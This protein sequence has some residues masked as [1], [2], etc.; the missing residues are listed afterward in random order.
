MHTPLYFCSFR[1]RSQ[2]R[3]RTLLPVALPTEI[4]CRKYSLRVY[5]YFTDSFVNQLIPVL[6]SN[7]VFV[8]RTPCTTDLVVS[9]TKLKIVTFA[10]YGSINGTRFSSHQVVYLVMGLTE[11]LFTIQSI[12][13]EGWH[14][15]HERTS[16]IP[17]RAMF[18]YAPSVTT[19]IRFYETLVMYVVSRDIC[20]RLSNVDLSE[21]QSPVYYRAH[22]VRL[23]SWESD[24]LWN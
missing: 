2:K 12:V 3:F 15:I 23:P 6:Q 18:V 14:W 10:K 7:T 1:V 16:S 11:T 22:M 17:Q 4:N 24:A 20:K 19:E 9:S 8:F 21:T 5:L 13:P